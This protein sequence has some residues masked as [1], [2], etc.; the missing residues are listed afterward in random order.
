M[1]ILVMLGPHIS[2]P[3]RSTECTL[4][5]STETRFC[6]RIICGLFNDAVSNH[7]ASNGRIM[8]GRDV[9]GICHD[10]IGG[11]IQ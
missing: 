6:T 2:Y 7:V 4:A 1:P 9:E 3:K 11:I 8:T 10:A 5:Y